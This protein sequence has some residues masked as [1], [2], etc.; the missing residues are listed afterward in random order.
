MYWI[1]G[2]FSN[3]YVTYYKHLEIEV[4]NGQNNQCEDSNQSTSVFIC[5]VSWICFHF[6]DLF[7]DLFVAYKDNL[8]I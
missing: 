6:S 4:V 5:D 3:F 1:R 7:R 2:L 8:W